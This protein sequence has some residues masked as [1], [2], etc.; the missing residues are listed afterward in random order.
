MH[1]TVTPLVDPPEKQNVIEFEPDYLLKIDQQITLHWEQINVFTP[2]TTKTLFNKIRG[3]N[4]ESNSRKII[5]D[6]KSF[7]PF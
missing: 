2:D 3:K 1:R 7:F 4:L 6:G 5:K